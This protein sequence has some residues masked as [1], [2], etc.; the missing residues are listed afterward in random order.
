M[1]PVI[2]HPEALE[3]L[4]DADRYYESCQIGLGVRFQELIEQIESDIAEN[5]ETGFIHDHGTRMRLVRK[6]PYGVIFKSYSDHIFI[7]AIAHL[8]RRPGYW[9]KRVGKT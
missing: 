4:A 1:T 9:R 3:E 2:Y 5:P 6:F 8:S 7:V